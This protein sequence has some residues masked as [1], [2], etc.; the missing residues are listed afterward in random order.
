MFH[1][2][3]LNPTVARCAKTDG[4][5]CR[6][7]MDG[8]QLFTS[9]ILTWEDRIMAAALYDIPVHHIDSTPASLADH[10]GS[11]ML[12]V[13]VASQCGL[14]P[15][16][17]DL[18]A[19]YETYR[20]R[21]FV[22]LGFPANE[23][24]GQEP[25]SNQEIQQFCETKFGVKF[26]M[27]EKIVVK[28]EGQHPL[29]QQLIAALPNAQQKPNGTLRKTLDQHGLGPKNDT[30]IMWNFEKFLINRKGEVVGRFAP[31]I[32]PK[33]PALTSAIEAE[34]SKPA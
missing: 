15:Q 11:V 31:D 3:E 6:I 5:A 28:G 17:A 34:L 23:F 14:T 4:S 25:G 32:A 12:I 20:D 9:K 24:A 21:G 13:N 26:P 30:D 8:L 10:K 7:T 2:K 1:K 18:E 27:F 29:Y 33:D 16:Y 22:V 19:I